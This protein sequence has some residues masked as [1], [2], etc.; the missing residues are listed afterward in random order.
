MAELYA[1]QGLYEDALGVYRQLAER[2]PIDEHIR[3][4]IAEL[5]Q[6]MREVRTTPEATGDLAELLELTEPPEAEAADF[7]SPTPSVDSPLAPA[8]P[9]ASEAEFAFEDEAPGAGF[10]QL[11][12][13]ASSFDV[14]IKRDG[15]V[16]P[17][18]VDVEPG[19]P[20]IRPPD[21]PAGAEF[22]EP[23]IAPLE[24]EITPAATDLTP[25]AIDLTPG[26]EPDLVPP[27]AHIPPPVEAPAPAAAAPS[28]AAEPVPSIE[29]YLL[30][31]LGYDPEARPAPDAVPVAQ[32]AGGPVTPAPGAAAAPP[33]A[34]EPPSGEAAK[35]EDPEDL[36]QFQEW[37]RGLKD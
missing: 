23:E 32:P 7:A 22:L 5:E 16:V 13:F 1:D 21:V 33:E 3:G 6:Q 9:A 34:D 36:E 26:T 18:P 28:P 11:D 24:P 30:G 15:A 10:E 37:L 20:P 35:P 17:R 29:D 8:E 19:A 27:G 31:L 25:A 14:L 2:R 4:R 12:P